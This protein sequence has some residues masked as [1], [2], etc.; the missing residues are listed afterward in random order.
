MPEQIQ[1]SNRETDDLKGTKAKPRSVSEIKVSLMV[2]KSTFH[3]KEKNVAEC[4]ESSAGV[5][6]SKSNRD[7]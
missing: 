5:I 4:E 6:K 2:M 1:N 3:W 7:Q